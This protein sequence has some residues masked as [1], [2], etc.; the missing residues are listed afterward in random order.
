MSSIIMHI[1]ISKKIQEEL[2]L[3][4]KF[5]AGSVLPDMIKIKTMDR[6]GTHY[7]KDI[8]NS[9]K[10]LPDLER[11]LDENKNKLNDEVML[12]YYAHL[13][14]DK[15]WFDKYID[16]FAKCIDEET[17]LYTSDNTIHST[18]EFRKDMY[19]DYVS[20][21][22]YLIKQSNMD[23]DN[24]RLNIKK[25]LGNYDVDEVVNENII[26]PIVLNDARIIFISQSC[27][28][29]YIIE[30]VNVVKNEIK[31]IIGE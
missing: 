8:E 5:L 9:T 28:E 18:E 6:R 12:G 14:E 20:V 30:S 7:I 26:F 29:D 4:N 13:I 16:S 19:S 24:I 23:I 27:L 15:L 2:N 22:K 25:E 3:S 17:I 21:D 11:F 10:R 1:Y 31:R